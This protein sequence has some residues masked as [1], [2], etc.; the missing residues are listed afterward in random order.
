MIP[1]T[2]PRGAR[3]RV[4]KNQKVEDELKKI[5]Q[6]QHPTFTAMDLAKRTNNMTNGIGN[7][8]R[9]TSG[10]RHQGKGLWAFTGEPIRVME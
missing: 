10:V 4:S 8:L 7:I 6:A 9:F 2:I 3:C 1:L 5:Q